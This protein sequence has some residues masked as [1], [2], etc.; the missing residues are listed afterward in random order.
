MTGMRTVFRFLARPGRA[1]LAAGLF[2]AFTLVSCVPGDRPAN[3]GEWRAAVDSV[4]ASQVAAWN[5]GDIAGYMEGYWKSDSLLFTS[6]GKVR[7]GWRETFAKYSAAY[8]T[9]GKM[10]RLSFSGLEYYFLSPGAVWV[11]GNWELERE[12]DHP[13]GVFTIIVSKFPGGWRIV[14]DHTSSAETP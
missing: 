1:G 2:L 3:D 6:G 13:G 12:G 9:P 4:L 7:R 11:F 5:R 8:D 14:H 10:G